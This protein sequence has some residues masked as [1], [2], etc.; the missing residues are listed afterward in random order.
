[1]N[2]RR[3]QGLLELPG[4]CQDRWSCLQRVLLR[5]VEAVVVAGR[6]RRRC[7]EEVVEQARVVL[8]PL[9]P[10]TRQYYLARVSHPQKASYCSLAY[11]W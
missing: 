5:L 3:R 1:M 10:H 8:A 7:P 6:L 4:L 11:L 9:A 2:R